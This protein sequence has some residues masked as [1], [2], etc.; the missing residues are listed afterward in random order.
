MSSSRNLSHK[1]VYKFTKAKRIVTMASNSDNLWTRYRNL[2]NRTK[3]ACNQ[4]LWEFLEQLSVK[5]AS[6]GDSKL[7][8]NYVHSRRNGTNNLVT[9]KVDTDTLTDHKDIADSF[10]R[11]FASVFTS[12]NLTHFPNFPQVVNTENLTQASTTPIEVGKLLRELNDNKSCGPDDIHPRILKHCSNSLASP[13]CA[14][15]NTSF[16]CGEIPV[17]W[18]IANVI[19]LCKKGAKDKVENYRPVSLTSIASKICEKIVRKNRSCLSQLRDTFHSRAKARNDSH[20]DDV[21]MVTSGVPKIVC[22]GQYCS[23]PIL[24]ILQLA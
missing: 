4:P 19:P 11:Y 2:N 12:G 17:D 16:K 1:K 20:N 9:L 13:L 5:T 15:F 22:L 7:F 23:L 24:T 10:N 6:E 14:L 8:W 21:T 18:K 3:K